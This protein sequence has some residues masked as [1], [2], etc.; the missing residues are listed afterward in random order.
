VTEARVVD[1]NVLIVASAADLTSPFGP[2]DTPVD[3]PA[4]RQQVLEW[5][6]AFELD[7]QRHA[8]L[9]WGWA[10]FGEYK[11]KLTDQDYGVLALMAKRDRNEV[12]WVNVELDAHGDAVL[13]AALSA[14]VTDRADRKMVA[15]AI[16]SLAQQHA[17]KLTN[18]CDTDWFDCA[19]A[20]QARGVEFEHLI[21]AWLR[22]KWAAKKAKA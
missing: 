22:T 13:D 16:A 17:C 18:A 4:L 5:L 7:E 12:V 6:N 15:G 9:D 21:E 20:V 11:N 8:V 10:I 19:V 14:A 3:D 2:D 1:T